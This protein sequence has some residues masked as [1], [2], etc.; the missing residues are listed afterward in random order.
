METSLHGGLSKRRTVI[1]QRPRGVREAPSNPSSVRQFGWP[2]T[3][4]GRIVKRAAAS[5]RAVTAIFDQS[6]CPGRGACPWNKDSRAVLG[7]VY[8]PDH[9]L[10]PF[11]QGARTG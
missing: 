7:S 11:T 6:G 10:L 9:P 2:T 5:D 1:S 4:R 8:Q 3:I